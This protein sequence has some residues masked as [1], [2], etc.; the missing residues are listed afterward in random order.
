MESAGAEDRN[1]FDNKYWKMR[2]VI[3]KPYSCFYFYRNIEFILLFFLI[4]P[5]EYPNLA[6]NL[7]SIPSFSD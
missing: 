7:I 2:P 1:P 4:S 6:P 5:I 3:C